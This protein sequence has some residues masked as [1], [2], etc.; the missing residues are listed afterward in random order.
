MADEYHAGKAPKLKQIDVLLCTLGISG[1]GLSQDL[2]PIKIIYKKVKYHMY[3]ISF[4]K[5]SVRSKKSV[6]KGVENGG[7]LKR[8]IHP[9]IFFYFQE[10]RK[11]NLVKT[12]NHYIDL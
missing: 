5:S 9:V 2:E 1:I 12:V 3:T 7:K 6:I 8:N 11:V 4:A 10:R